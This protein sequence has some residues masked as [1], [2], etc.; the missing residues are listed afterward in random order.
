MKPG[1]DGQAGGIDSARGGLAGEP[2]HGGDPALADAD[3]ADEGRIAG[4]VDDAAAEDEE[5]EILR[6]GDRD[7]DRKEKPKLHNGYNTGGVW[8]TSS[9]LRT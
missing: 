4:A 7:Q 8:Q 2:A 1:G 3:V 9:T 5:I 6:R